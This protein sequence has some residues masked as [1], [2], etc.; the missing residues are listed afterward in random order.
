MIHLKLIR[1]REVIGK[2]VATRHIY[3]EIVPF[4]NA[5]VAFAA[6]KPR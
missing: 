5:A 1:A 2:A 6:M 4:Q 3:C